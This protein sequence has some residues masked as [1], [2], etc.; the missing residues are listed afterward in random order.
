MPPIDA[1]IKIAVRNS[2]RATDKSPNHIPKSIQSQVSDTPAQIG[3]ICMGS[4]LFSSHVIIVNRKIDNI[5]IIILC[6]DVTQHNPEL[7]E[8]LDEEY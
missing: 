5:A 3:H 1:P 4:F 7:V 2:Y 6:F 8:G